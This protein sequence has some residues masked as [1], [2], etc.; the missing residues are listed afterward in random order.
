MLAL[1]SCADVGLNITRCTLV[2]MA[3]MSWNPQTDL[4]AQG[5]AWRIKQ[6]KEVVVRAMVHCTT[7]SRDIELRRESVAAE[8][9][10]AAVEYLGSS[11]KT[12]SSAKYH[13]KCFLLADATK[14]PQTANLAT[15]RQGRVWV[16]ARKG[17]VWVEHDVKELVF[18]GDC[19]FSAKFDTALMNAVF[20]TVAFDA[21]APGAAV[22]GAKAGVEPTV[23]TGLGTKT[24]ANSVQFAGEQTGVPEPGALCLQYEELPPLAAT[25]ICECLKKLQEG[26]DED[27][28]ADSDGGDE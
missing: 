5:R 17:A 4:Q 11:G 23:V 10:H 3:E 16:Q 21:G 20:T 8:K 14:S 2:V 28:G 1:K 26:G 25:S 9:A 19:A 18:L 12:G 15:V 22:T 24:S 13:V 6:T 7:F 27:G